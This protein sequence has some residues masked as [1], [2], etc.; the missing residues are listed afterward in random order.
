MGLL[1]WLWLVSPFA[2]I[3]LISHDPELL[4]LV[5]AHHRR[6]RAVGWTGAAIML[7]G[8]TLIPGPIG[9]LLFNAG[10]EQAD[11]LLAHPAL[12]QHLHPLLTR[13]RSRPRRHSPA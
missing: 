9:S 5:S 4:A 11:Q 6:C 7:L 3:A 13:R 10:S 8:V 1:G 12:E 2:V